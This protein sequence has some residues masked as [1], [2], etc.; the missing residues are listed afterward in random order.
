MKKLTLFDLVRLPWGSLICR[1]EEGRPSGPIW[2]WIAASEAEPPNYKYGY[3]ICLTPD[4]TAA[5][6]DATDD[7][8]APG[9]LNDIETKFYFRTNRRRATCDEVFWQFEPCELEFIADAAT[10]AINLF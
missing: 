6:F 10:R 3:A 9:L 8:E 5:G 4:G 7:F 2:K 1:D